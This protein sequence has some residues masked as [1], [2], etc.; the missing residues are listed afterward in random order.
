MMELNVKLFCFCKSEL[1]L[2]LQQSRH[3]HLQLQLLGLQREYSKQNLVLNSFP[4]I[5]LD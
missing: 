3:L 4:V 2:Q 1:Q 5:G